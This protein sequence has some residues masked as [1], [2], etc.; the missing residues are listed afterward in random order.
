MTG[1][2]TT[3]GTMDKTSY[4]GLIRLLARMTDGPLRFTIDAVTAQDDRI[5]A[6]A[7]S[8]GRLISGEDYTQ[9][10]VYVFRLRDG[11]IASVAEH[12]NALVAQEKLLP[13]MKELQ[14]S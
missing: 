9:T 14:T 6:E 8:A 11:R 10:Y 3:Q 5:V 2:I 1:W 13:L 12:Y 4:Q 7:R